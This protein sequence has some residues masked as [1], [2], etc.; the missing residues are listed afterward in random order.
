MQTLTC[1]SPRLPA[2]LQCNE[3]VAAAHYR[4]TP[5]SS[6]K[7]I[8]SRVQ[9]EPSDA[10]PIWQDIGMAAHRNCRVSIRVT[11]S[12]F[13]LVCTATSS[14][15]CRWALS[16]RVLQK[17][18]GHQQR[19]RLLPKRRQLYRLC[20]LTFSNRPVSHATGPSDPAEQPLLRCF[21]WRL[22]RGAVR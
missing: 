10:A 19:C 1:N 6:Q 11:A 8:P 20:T 14:D 2:V 16:S 22:M 13:K 12:F 5:M 17:H 4:S 9:C 21:D 15:S 3:V 7:H 18:S